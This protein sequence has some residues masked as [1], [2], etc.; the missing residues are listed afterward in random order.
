LFC[1]QVFN[2]NLN[3]RSGDTF[4]VTLFPE[5]L[6]AS[7]N[8]FQFASTAPGTYEVMDIG[9]FVS[10]FKAFDR[11]GTEIATEHSSTNEWTISRPQEVAKITY[12]VE[13]LWNAKVT[14]H[15]V[16]PM[17]STLLSDD[18]VM[19]NGQAIFGYFAGMQ[20]EP[21]KIKLS[22]PSEWTV[23]TA[24][25]P[26]SE[27]YYRADDFDNVV[28]SPFFLG[29]LSTAKTTVGNATIDVYTYSRT[30][31]ITSDKMLSSLDGLLK[32]ES[33]FTKGLP[34]NRYAF[35][36]YFG[37]FGAGAWEH[38]YSSEY[39]LKED[40][41]TPAYSA[42]IVSV[43]AH[44]FFHVNIPLNL[45]SELVEHFNFVK[46]VMSRHLWLYEGTTE[47][48]AF[49]L[50]LRDHLLTLPQYL[51][52]LQGKFSA[53]D[54]FDQHVSLTDLGIHATDMQDQYPNIYQK[55]A[56][57]ST[58]L[59]IRLLQLSH[60]KSGLRELILRLSK[61]YGKKHAFS[62]EDF[63]DKL[64][65]MTYPEIRD[66]IDHYIKGTDKLPAQEYFSSLGIDY[67]EKGM[68]DS[69]KSSLRAG[70]RFKDTSMVVTGVLDGSQS[71]LLKGDIIEKI[72]GTPVTTANAS[73]F[74]SKIVGMKLGST[75]TITVNRADKEIDVVSI[76]TPRLVRHT[77]SV[78][79]NPS[80][81]QSALRE[82]WMNNM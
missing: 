59:D 18:F 29:K 44:E 78:N 48:A 71:G 30:G 62:E 11:S 51:Q 57:V 6:S 81:E 79:P 19:L 54:N 21:I 66:F 46:P 15:P 16:Y 4:K 36:F 63:F 55:G 28:D 76:L 20:S 72:D 9:R 12:T 75:V 26:D 27:G 50:Q 67:S 60:G 38:S 33:N 25:N 37:K 1:H 73:L 70:I 74:T 13:D 10:S 68:A 3:D 61:E 43:I 82:S 23:G 80:A 5:P 49:T 17:A 8:V 32:A 22:Y 7:N 77:L 2:V 42:S 41:L 34:V 58:M 24:L 45:H 39:V 69:S 53:A 64:V 14:E 47:W 35:L 31:L 52:A 65:E 40:T 56:L